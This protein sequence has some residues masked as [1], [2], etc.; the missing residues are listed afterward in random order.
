MGFQRLWLAIGLNGHG[1]RTGWTKSWSTIVPHHRL[2]LRVWW[3]RR[4]VFSIR[5]LFDWNSECRRTRRTVRWRMR[6]M[7]WTHQAVL[8]NLLASTRLRHMLGPQNV[9]ANTLVAIL[10]LIV[11]AVHHLWSFYWFEVDPWKN[12][13][14]ML[15]LG[16]GRAATEEAQAARLRGLL[17][18]LLLS[19]YWFELVF[20]S[21]ILLVATCIAACIAARAAVRGVP[22]WLPPIDFAFINWWALQIEMMVPWD[23]DRIRIKRYWNNKWKCMAHCHLQS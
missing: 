15:L 19:R 11:V 21:A 14:L 8:E 5:W 13:S 10:D 20:V 22:V 17:L 4:R 23:N 2:I 6:R 16:I 7:L 18:L 12:I 1:H 9:A 3:L